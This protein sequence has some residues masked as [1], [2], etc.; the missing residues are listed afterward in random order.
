[1]KKK[2]SLMIHGGAGMNHD[3]EKYS[4]SLIAILETG[5]KMIANGSSSLDV[6][7]KC[8]SM[9]EDNPLYN[10]GCGSV[11]N[12]KGEVE[13]DASIMNGQNLA[14]GAVAAIK[15]IKNPVR[16]ARMILDNGR[17]V[18]LIADGAMEFAC[19]N[20]VVAMPEKYFLTEERRLQWEKAV[21]ENIIV[22]DHNFSQNKNEKFGT[23]GAVAFD[24]FGNLAAATSTGGLVNKKYGRVGDTPI[25][26]A[27]VYADN[28]TCAVS[29]TGI[30]EHFIKTVLAKTISEIIRHQGID[31]GEAAQMGIEYLTKKIEG[32]GG[33]IVVDK[34]GHCGSAF[35]TPA[36]IHGSVCD[37]GEIKLSF[38]T[39]INN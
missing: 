27:G 33:V 11:L 4:P 35:S 14:A 8:V 24:M 12:N 19:K 3:M 15:G 39:A 28:E 7:E 13:M 32:L 9:L 38:D 37:E 36:M 31:A 21:K 1:M 26:G 34:N 25:I 2:Y 23:V 10:A 30:G 18:M 20:G 5:R 17:H 29:A 16:L 22:L 6:V